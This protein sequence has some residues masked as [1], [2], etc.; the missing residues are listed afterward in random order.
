[1]STYE[2]V[3]L[4]SACL[5][6]CCLWTLCP[7]LHLVVAVNQSMAKRP[8]YPTWQDAWI[9]ICLLV[10]QEYLSECRQASLFICISDWLSP[11]YLPCMF[12]YSLLA[13]PATMFQCVF[14][15]SVL[16]LSANI[17]TSL[18]ACL[19]GSVSSHPPRLTPDNATR[20]G[21]KG[22]QQSSVKVTETWLTEQASYSFGGIN[23]AEQ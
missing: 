17:S 16:C 9:S 11:V 23:A 14:S 3:Y 5:S 15:S 12:W 8:T 4:D 6:K 7:L 1:M 18:P 20:A 19:F 10:W 13:C 22:L 2:S 21:N